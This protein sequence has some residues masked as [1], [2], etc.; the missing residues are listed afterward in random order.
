MKLRFF[1]SVLI[2]AVVGTIFLLN[3]NDNGGNVMA[4]E[5]PKTNKKVLVAYFSAS[6]VTAKVADKLAKATGADLFEIKPVQPYTNADL[7][8]TNKKSRS[9]VEMDDR[10]SRPAIA[11]KVSDMSKYDVVFVGFPIWW[12]REP[13]II[14]TFMESYD[15]SG[16]QVIP[17]ATS[18]GSGMGDSGSIMQKLAPKAKVDSGKRFSSG[19]SEADL[20][21]WAEKFF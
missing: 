17:F 2:V 14:D 11:N 20:K 4:E 13:S 9:S 6:G 10:S 8:W 18:G 21:A 12:Y 16:K 7:D 5:Q 1:V 3:S 19:V 15:F